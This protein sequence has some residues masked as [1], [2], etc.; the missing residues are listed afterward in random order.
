MKTYY[1]ISFIIIAVFLSG[2]CSAKKSFDYSIT[3]APQSL[4][5][6]PTLSDMNRVA[7]VINKRLVNFFNISKEN[8]KY[9]ITEYQISITI[10]KVETIKPD[11]VRKV[12]TDYSRLEFWETYENGEI[13]DRLTKINDLCSKGLNEPSGSADIIAQYPLFSKLKPMMTEKGESIPGCM[14]G[15]VNAK[16]TSEVSR[17]LKTDQIK[18]I[19]PG[20]IKF[21]WSSKPYRYDKSKSTYGLHAIKVTTDNGLAPLDGSAVI[22]ANTVPRSE[23]KEVKIDLSMDSAGALKWAQITSE[24]INRCI[25][26]VYEGSVRSYPRVMSEIPGGNTQITGDFSIEEANDLVNILKSG[27]MPF[28]VKIVN[29]QLKERK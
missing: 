20:N 9:D 10:E 28:R 25:A 5:S 27:E 21:L 2:G 24:N 18:T 3:V 12:I 19:L 4:K 14:I 11:L 7:D 23:S 1:F 22:S 17:I 15:L 26:V 13:S 6:S 29:E 8:I 16:D